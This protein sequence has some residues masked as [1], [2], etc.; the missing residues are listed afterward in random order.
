[1]AAE[2]LHCINGREKSSPR[3]SNT[4]SRET[5]V[6]HSEGDFFKLLLH[7]SGSDRLMEAVRR[8][9]AICKGW[10]LNTM[11]KGL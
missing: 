1:M 6:S 11:R 4:R 9:G 2:H 7:N 5:Q 10:S 3:H 8:R